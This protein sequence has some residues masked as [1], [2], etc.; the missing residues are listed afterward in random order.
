MSK[1]I[2]ND[3]V[4]LN[5]LVEEANKDIGIRTGNSVYKTRKGY[6]AHL[7]NLFIKLREMS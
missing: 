2:V 1:L 7:I 4:L 5:F 6:A 3:D